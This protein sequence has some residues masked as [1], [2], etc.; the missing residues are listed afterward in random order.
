MVSFYIYSIPLSIHTHLRHNTSRT[1][2]IITTTYYHNNCQ[3]L[4]TVDICVQPFSIYTFYIASS[5]YTNNTHLSIY[6]KKMNLIRFIFKQLRR[7][8]SNMRPPGYEPGELP[9]APLRDIQTGFLF[10]FAIAKV[11]NTFET[12]KFLYK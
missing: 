4:P 9:T 10:S 11:S 1:L 5:L 12:T 8:D 6:K 7:Q 3:L 2:Y